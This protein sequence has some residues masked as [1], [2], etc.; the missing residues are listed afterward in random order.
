MAAESWQAVEGFWFGGKDEGVLVGG[1]V[2]GAPSGTIT[3]ESEGLGFGVPVSVNEGRSDGLIG[4]WEWK[5][6]AGA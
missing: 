6:L 1:V 4:W 3:D 2:D 5:V